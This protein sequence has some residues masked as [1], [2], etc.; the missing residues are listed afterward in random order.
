MLKTGRYH[1]LH[2]ATLKQTLKLLGATLARKTA[3]KTHHITKNKQC[4]IVANQRSL[5]NG[6]R[7]DA[8]DLAAVVKIVR[9]QKSHRTEKS[10]DR[11]IMDRNSRITGK[12]NRLICKSASD[13]AAL[14]ALC[15]LL[16]FARRIHPASFMPAS[17]Q[18]H[19]RRGPQSIARRRSNQ[20]AH[21]R[22]LD[23]SSSRPIF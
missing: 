21:Y 6:S 22:R 18:L 9:R 19:D 4:N 12:I 15:A 1:L 17:C 14:L 5:N 2:S 20:H 8:A 7:R 10:R 13:V 11:K 23:A 3:N 16:G